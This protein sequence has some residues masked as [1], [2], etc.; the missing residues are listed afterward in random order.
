MMKVLL[1]AIAVVAALAAE[2]AK[3]AAPLAAAKAEATSNAESDQ[4]AQ[5]QMEIES[6]KDKV[7]AMKKDNDEMKAVRAKAISAAAMD[8]NPTN[9]V[10]RRSDMNIMLM[11]TNQGRLNRD[12]NIMLHN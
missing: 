3:T 7:A 8:E 11:Q 5:L 9:K 12:I 10:L 4:R 1:L 6:L 2:P